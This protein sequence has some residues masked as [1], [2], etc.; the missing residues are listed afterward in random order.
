MN[1]KYMSL[2]KI[3]SAENNWITAGNLA[4]RLGL[5]IRTIKKYISEINEIDCQLVF[6]SNK[7]YMV[8]S[9][10]MEKYIGEQNVIP[11][12]SME[13]RNYL[14]KKMLST[15]SLNI[16]DLREEIY[17]SES[18]IKSDL[19]K[20]RKKLEEYQLQL[21]T[22]GY[23]VSLEGDEKSKRKLMSSILYEEIHKRYLSISKLQEYYQEYDISYLADLLK[24]QFEKNSYYINDYAFIN[25]LLHIMIQI[26]RMK[27]HYVFETSKGEFMESSD[28]KYEGMLQQ[29]VSCVEYKYGVH[30]LEGEINELNLML[31]SS[32]TNV[33]YNKMDIDE[34]KN[35]IGEEYIDLTLE[36]IKEINSYY[37]TCQ[38]LKAFAFFALH[39][40]NLVIRCQNGFM[41]N[42]P[43]ISNIQKNYPVM[44][45]CAINLSHV[46]RR[47]TGYRINEDEI[48]YI[49][50]HIG[51]VILSQRDFNSR[52]VCAVLSPEYYGLK[53]KL[54]D[55]L[56]SLF[57]DM[58]E[59]DSILTSEDN[60]K[61]TSAD[62]IISTVQLVSFYTIPHI[63]VSPF[64]TE[65]DRDNISK[66]FSAILLKRKKAEFKS[67]LCK[68]TRREFF[69]RGEMMENEEQAIRQICAV[70]EEYGY[71]NKTFK[72]EIFEREKLASTA[73]GNV[74]IPHSMKMNA[75]K[76]GMYI[77]VSSEGIQWNE[78]KVNI[79]LLLSSNTQ[80]RKV[81]L[82]VFENL[83]AILVENT[84]REKLL[85]CVD[86]DSFLSVLADCLD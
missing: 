65:C 49:A 3:L 44:Y 8:N 41:L 64:L 33:D 19:G 7:G 24:E 81:F 20:L 11:Q 27:H 17:V 56:S 52:I 47:I 76:T 85:K 30:Y 58:I 83:S 67:N 4:I 48:T 75:K 15:K 1:S 59:I 34:L 6:S 46:F 29:I 21:V 80:E 23:S 77:V 5:S 68:I 50:I 2:L 72:Q 10:V 31:L 79:V 40:K 70:M 45:D 55:K 32:I 61:N 57:E 12:T 53:M 82:D 25:L 38:D 42:N 36:L 60:L 39:I 35:T 43:L 71:V 73:F 16:L 22:K 14:I 74:A 78:E 54:V 18:T 26:D 86:Y 84:K 13:R 62:V 63:V 28:R 37:I 51:N 9:E 69:S 66:L